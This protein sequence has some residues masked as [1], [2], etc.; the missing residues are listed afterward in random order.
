[1]GFIGYGEILGLLCALIWATSGLVIRN[2]VAAHP[3]AFLNALRCGSAALFVWALMPFEPP[4]AT[5]LQVTNLEWALLAGSVLLALGVG[6]T[7]YMVSLREIGVARAL[8]ISG[9]FPL[10]TLFFEW[11]ILDHAFSGTFVL[12]CVLVV[13]GIVVLSGRTPAGSPGGAPDAQGRPWR[14]KGVAWGTAAGLLAS[15]SWGLGTL[16]TA[17]AITHL[18][19]IQANSIRLPLVSITMLLLLRA[20]GYTPKV[21][22]KRRPL[23][24]IGCSGVLGMGL[25]SFLYLEALQ[26]IGAAKTTTL[27]ATAPLFGLLVTTLIFREKVDPRTIAGVALCIAG[28]WLVL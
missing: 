27:A 9:T 22:L 21:R 23:I 28:V 18:T 8:A 16:M 11:L 4:M 3:P 17:E 26:Q 20:T 10:P 5:F 13:A 2:Y 25:G 24:I 6:D 14:G 15:A 12:G 1:L 19:A 7:L